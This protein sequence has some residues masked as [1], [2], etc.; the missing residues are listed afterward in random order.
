MGIIQRQALRNTIINFAGASL[1]GAMRLLMPIFMPSKAAVGLL[2]ILDAFSASFVALFSL[3]YNQILIKLFP[4]FRDDEKGHHGLLILGLFL[5]L[6]GILV[7]FVIYYFFGEMMLNEDA[8]LVLFRRFS[9]LIFPMIFFRII[10]LNMDGYARMLYKTFIGVF[11]DTFLSKV[12][13]AFAVILY[14]ALWISFDYFVYLYALSFCIPGFLISIFAF[15]KTPKVVLPSKDLLAPSERK[16][17]YEYII[18]GMLIGASGSIV[19]YVDTLMLTKMISLDAVAIYSVMF[20]AARFILIPSAAIIR[21]A[22][23]VLAEAWQKD[24]LETVRSVYTKSCVNQLLIGAFLLGLGWT[25]LGPVFSLHVKFDDYSPY[26]YLFLILGSGILIEMATGVN[27]AI[28]GTSRYYKYN[29]YFNIVLAVLCIVLN[30]FM[31][32]E[33]QLTGAAV[34]SVIAMTIVNFFRW[35]L[36]YRKYN[37][38]PFNFVFVKAAFLSIGFLA[39]C[40]YLDY[41]AN[42]FVKIAINLAALTLLFWGLVIVLKLSPDVNKWLAKMKTK[43]F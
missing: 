39:L 26:S 3:G 41:E 15:I 29:M 16:G 32:K 38:Q 22:Q 5:S 12:F 43:F 17:I 18:F 6:I 19:L 31:I 2:G 21:I 9:F 37:L 34:A 28:I 30:Y 23:V 8:D 25:V 42:A 4:R 35:L 33:Y 10:F 11:L 27:T 13:I 40:Y 14:A 20:F 36:L 7:S 24:D 1:G